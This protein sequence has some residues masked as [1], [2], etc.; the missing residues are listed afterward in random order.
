MSMDYDLLRLSASAILGFAVGG[1]LAWWL[2]RRRLLTEQRAVQD[3][4]EERRHEVVRLT[5]EGAAARARAEQVPSL[6][7]ALQK[8]DRQLAELQHQLTEASQRGAR[9]E[10]VIRRDRQAMRE[11]LAFMEDWQTRMGDA[12]KALSATALREN[13]QV[14]LDL[15]QSALARQL[16]AARSDLT[17]RSQAVETMLNP[18]RDALTRY[19]QQVLSLER[20]RENAYGELRQQLQTMAASQDLFRR[21][22]GKLVKALRVPHVRGRWGEI[23][24]KRVAE[25]AGLQAH[26][27]FFEQPST[28]G[29]KG[30]LRPDMLVRLPGGRL[31]LVDAKVP[32]TAYLDALETTSEKERENHLDRHAQQVASHIQQLAAKSYWAHFDPTPEFVV[33][34]IPGENFF[35]AAL[36][37]NPGLI[38]SGV[39]KNVILATPTTL[40]ALLKAVAY[41]WRQDQAAANAENVC[42]QGRELYERL[43][44]MARHMDQ[45]GKALES[46]VQHYNRMAGSLERRVLTAARRFEDLGV[47]ADAEPDL[48]PPRT[49]TQTPRSS[50]F[51]EPPK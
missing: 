6:E 29:D 31:I 27:D 26:C 10:T 14:F 4:L 17:Q 50:N 48:A 36:S 25:M 18:I 7:N 22:T 35:S 12:Y 19:D 24:L 40:I 37:R 1:G 21:E 9:L 47:V 46:C 15:A 3:Q 30:R 11:K 51:K 16:D 41:G 5:E 23:T 38:E 33:L 44:V 42:R 39:Q 2:G 8:R 20:A 49:I 34:F 43:Q 28:A 45:M 32:L 13:N